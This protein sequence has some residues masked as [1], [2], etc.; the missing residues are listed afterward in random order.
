MPQHPTSPRS[1]TTHRDGAATDWND[2]ETPSIATNG[3]DAEARAD[4]T[5]HRMD[6]PRNKL[7]DQIHVRGL[8]RQSDRISRSVS[9]DPA[10]DRHWISRPRVGSQVHCAEIWGMGGV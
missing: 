5:Y 9:S 2:S 6:R 7:L 8:V 3:H 1:E 4:S 10:C